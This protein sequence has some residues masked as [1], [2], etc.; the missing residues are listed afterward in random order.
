MEQFEDEYFVFNP[1]TGHTHVLNTLGM[2]SLQ[3]LS[4]SAKSN[5][6][7][8]TSLQA[9]APDITAETLRSHIDQQL[10]QMEQLGLVDQRP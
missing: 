5:D 6:E 9:Q 4:E 1:E 7:L 2:M 10:R 3:L 8:F